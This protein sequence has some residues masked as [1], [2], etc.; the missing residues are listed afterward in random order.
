MRRDHAARFVV[1]SG[2]LVGRPA[3]KQLGV[4]S[5]A[6]AAEVTRKVRERGIVVWIDAE[7]QFSG[8]VD[9]LAEGG[10]DFG[11]KVARFRGSYLEL[12]LALEDLKDDVY[13]DKVLVHLAG[14]NK[15]TVKETPAL[16]L[17]KAGSVFEKSLG[18]VVRDA[19]VGVVA[20]PRSRCAGARRAPACLRAPGERASG[21]DR[22][23]ED[24]S[25]RCG[26]RFHRYIPLRRGDHPRR[27]ALEAGRRGVGGCHR[28]R[29]QVHARGVFLGSPV[30]A[31]SADVGADA[32]RRQGR[33]RNGLHTPGAR[34]LQ[35]T[36]RSRRTVRDEA[37]SC[38]S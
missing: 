20:V 36:G 14:L 23:G 12:M 5:Q 24:E 10:C 22:A 19:A 38:G 21:R 30:G 25:P 13:P 29:G 18:R 17:Y 27:H 6:L 15:E 37:C 16:E 3:L 2:M 33:A 31:A 7:R 28:L 34:P 11:Y 9:A 26:P 1:K 32:P 35:L 4:A 8:L